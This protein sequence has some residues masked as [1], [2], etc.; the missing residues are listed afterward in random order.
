MARD[1]GKKAPLGHLH[2]RCA[3][4]TDPNCHWE[5]RGHDDADIMKQMEQHAHEAH[6]VMHLDNGARNRIR[7]VI[8]D[9]KAA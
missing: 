8:H 1:K 6:N 5:V 4:V 9:K 3:D 2:L 7:S